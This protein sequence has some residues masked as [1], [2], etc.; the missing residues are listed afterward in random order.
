M[1]DH[2]A[3]ELVAIACGHACGV[4]HCPDAAN[5]FH[6]SADER[7]AVA[8]RVAGHEAA[9]QRRDEATVEF[10]RRCLDRGYTGD[11]L[12]EWFQG[13][14]GP[15]SR[16]SVYRARAALR[17]HGSKVAQVAAEARA[18]VEAARGDEGAADNGD[19]LFAAASHR[20]GQLAFQ[21]LMETSAK[22]LGGEGVNI[23]KLVSIV[24][25]LAKLTKA[26]AETELLGEKVAAMRRA[27]DAEVDAARRNAEGGDGTITP[28]QIT[29]IRDA[30]FG[31]GSGHG[32]AA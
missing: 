9:R 32:R 20:Y 21:L 6:L 1:T 5:A 2:K 13:L 23:S 30:V 26:R 29:A 25:A 15:I 18:F 22:E 24:S 31:S 28:D 11:Q 17:A 8:A 16:S 27:F 3:Y 12:W 4:E 14:Y 10:E 7:Q 19:A